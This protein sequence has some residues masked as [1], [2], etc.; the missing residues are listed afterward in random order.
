M[1][2]DLD[3][4]PRQWLVG[5]PFANY[6]WPGLIL[7]FVVGGSAAVAALSAWRQT[8]AWAPAAIVAGLVLV[9]WIA[10]E[11]TLLNQNG[12]ASSP[13]GPFEVIYFVAGVALMLLG[14]LAWRSERKSV[15]RP[16]EGSPGPGR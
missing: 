4:F 15:R 13:R 6:V 10:G 12:T 3:R 2:A 16:T 1:A 7:A 8:R 14:A 11:T 5:S 9:G